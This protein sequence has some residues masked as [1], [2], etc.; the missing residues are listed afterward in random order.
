MQSREGPGHEQ[1]AKTCAN[2]SD[3]GNRQCKSEMATTIT[4]N[5]NATD[6]DRISGMPA[7]MLQR[8][9]QRFSA[10]IVRK[11]ENHELTHY[12]SLIT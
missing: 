1:A 9:L 2:E 10:A 8:M 5:W 3:N 11:S 6:H 7:K 12:K 4:V